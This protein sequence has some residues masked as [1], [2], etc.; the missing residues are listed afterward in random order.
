MK[1]IVF[2]SAILIIYSCSSD[3]ESDCPPIDELS[4]NYHSRTDN[5]CSDQDQDGVVDLEDNCPFFPNANQEDSDND[6]IG[7]SCDATAIFNSSETSI[8]VGQSVSFLSQS[9]GNPT[10]IAWAF[11]RGSPETSD[12]TSVNVTYNSIGNF[13]VSLFVNNEYFDDIMVVE[14]YI[15]VCYN[16]TFGNNQFDGWNSN[17]WQFSSSQVCPD[18]IY[19]WQ[20]STSPGESLSLDICRDFTNLPNN[21]TFYFDAMGDGTFDLL[22]R[23]KVKINNINLPVNTIVPAGLTTLGSYSVDLPNNLSDANICL[24]ATLFS[25]NNIY[26]NN[27]RVCED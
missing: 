16:K 13:D 3:S 2:L 20:N 1:L 22:D 18:C 12:Q 23:L 8:F 5:A 14:D 6:G 15:S 24:I 26:L 17:G 10:S 21:A 4:L 7:N 19:A 9:T 27:L 25:T 11:E